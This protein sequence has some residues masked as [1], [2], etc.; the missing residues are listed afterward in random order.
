MFQL[1]N[2]LRNRMMAQHFGLDPKIRSHEWNETERQQRPDD[3][4]LQRPDHYQTNA[5]ELA[6]CT[7]PIL[8][9]EACLLVATLYTS[10]DHA[11][12][13]IDHPATTIETTT[14]LAIQSLVSTAPTVPLAPQQTIVPGTIQFQAQDPMS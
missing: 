11:M 8:D 3:E 7:D 5:E 1:F 13:E 4:I 12:D 10:I 2:D 14:P 9:K 6:Q